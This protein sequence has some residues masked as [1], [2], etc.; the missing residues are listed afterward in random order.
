[1]NLRAATPQ[2]VAAITALETMIFGPQAWSVRSVQ[3]ELSSDDRSVI[4]AIRGE[5]LLGYA[6]AMR[7]ADVV[8][9]HR[10]GVHP[11]HRRTG[12]A[13]LLLA[14]SADRARAHSVERMLLEVDSGNVAARGFY[15]R[16]GFV[17]ID[18]R[19]RYYSD[20]SDALVLERS[21]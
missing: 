19:I 1:M 14:A 3:E 21:L 12:V 4:V 18:R 9:L 17:Q 13:H 8:D 5:L 20:G 2:D 11:D 7:S 10:I 15:E 16:E 6:I